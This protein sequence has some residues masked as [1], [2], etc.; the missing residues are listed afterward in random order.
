MHI[1]ISSGDLALVLP[2]LSS[3]L[4][5][6]HSVLARKSLSK[7]T[8]L[9]R[10][11]WGSSESEFVTSRTR[12]DITSKAKHEMVLDLSTF[13][14]SFFLSSPSALLLLFQIRFVHLEFPVSDHVSCSTFRSSSYQAW[15][16]CQWTS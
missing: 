15:M 6:K 2:I 7:C 5:L 4:P 8:K 14:F 1:H 10:T 11:E 9:L 3:Y 12:H 16:I 13:F